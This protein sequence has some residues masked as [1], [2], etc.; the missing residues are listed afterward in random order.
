MPLLAR[1]TFLALLAALLPAAS[2]AAAPRLDPRGL[3][4][5]DEAIVRFEPGTTRAERAAARDAANVELEETLELSQTQVVSFDGSLDDAVSRLERRDDVAYAQPNYRYKALATAP[6][7]SF[8]GLQWGL[9]GGYGVL[10]LAAWDS[11]RG[12]GQV[13]AIVDS[14]IDLTHPDLRNKL[15][16]NPG[17]A[18]GGGDNDG[19]GNGDDVRGYDFV[20]DDANP[21]DFEFHGTHVAGIAGAQ[22]GNAIGVAGVAP[23][24]SLMAVRVLDGN[25][26][27]ASSSIAEGIAYAAREGA[28]VINLSLG[29]LA[30]AGDQLVSDALT[31]ARNRDAV[32]VAAAGNESRNNDAISYTPCVLPG[33]NLICVAALR[34]DGML[35][36]FSN[37]GATTVD[38]AAPGVGVLSTKTDYDAPLLTEDFEDGLTDWE[39]YAQQV[40]A[41][42][43]TS[44]Q[45]YMS[46]PRSAS[47]SPF[48][49][50]ASNTYT[51]IHRAPDL[52]LSGERGCRMHFELR[53]DVLSGDFFSAGA[54][55]GDPNDPDVVATNSLAGSSG[56]SFVDAAAS[57]SEFDGRSDVH[58]V[59]ALKTNATGTADGVH[60]DDLRVFCRDTTYAN[61]VANAG[62]Y[63]EPGSGSY[64]PFDGTSMAAPHV[65][66]IAALVRAAYPSASAD[67]VVR[68]I[69][70]GATRRPSLT[71]LV[72]TAGSANAAG[73]LAALAPAAPNTTT[74]VTPPVARRFIDL[75]RA[76]KR[77]RLKRSGRFV[78][79]FRTTPGLRGK[80]V[81]KTT[82]RVL[83][84][85]G[86]R[87]RHLTAVSKTF[88]APASGRVTLTLKLSRKELR[89]ARLNKG[90]R[91]RVVISVRDAQGRT[92]RAAKLTLLPPR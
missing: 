60:L 89:I 81:M 71:G 47:D 40:G 53:Y 30:N 7:D 82:R 28:D 78:Y 62:N 70:N 26:F 86:G 90:L 25:G 68:A 69:K 87:R 12:N 51:E 17:E 15:W 5:A 24:A 23:G 3:E 14:G 36:P 2:A 46:Q 29:R 6:N 32:V 75:R 66:G 34:Q 22:A 52:N 76:K 31:T 57:I 27:G 18:P 39:P 88:R 83:L 38:V 33:G 45:V 16:Q 91:L 63:S 84:K 43:G 44:T 11:S 67:D 21:D 20:D 58:P 41:P 8:F 64:V 61:G 74:P 54:L 37:Y 92:V 50:Y 72:A 85:R 1:L 48:G 13:I 56:G 73:A 35:A 59:F 77:I 4:G 9:G 79:A 19:N 80:A 42:W 55:V 49:W 65:S 10:A